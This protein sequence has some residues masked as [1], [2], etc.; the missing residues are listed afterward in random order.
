MSS[1]ESGTAEKEDDQSV[2]TDNEKNSEQEDE[3][4]ESNQSEQYVNPHD[5]VGVEG[6]IR[7][8]KNEIEKK[9][10]S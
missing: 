5:L 4:G 7:A 8:Q 2:Q 1:R 6:I 3:Y 10:V 9:K